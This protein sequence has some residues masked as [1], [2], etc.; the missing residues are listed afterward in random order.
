MNPSLFM[1]AMASLAPHAFADDALSFKRTFATGQSARYTVVMGLPGLSVTGDVETTV[2]KLLP[3]GATVR[4]RAL[5][6]EGLPTN[7]PLPD[8]TTTTGPMGMPN[9]A[10]IKNAQEFFIF[11]GAAGITPNKE[12]HVGDIV[13]VHWQNDPMD[14]TFDGHGKL[15]KLDPATKRLTVEW[16]LSMKPSYTTAGAVTFKSVY[17]T[18]DF[19]LVSSDGTLSVG[20][21]SVTLKCTRVPQP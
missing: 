10:S 2:V 6:L 13:P 8:L 4:W 11:L 15:V 12:A 3:D 17:S 9:G 21:A 7:D 1:V 19:S 14:V 5:K 20:G 16:D 18:T